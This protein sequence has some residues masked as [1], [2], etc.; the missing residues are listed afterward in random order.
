MSITVKQIAEL[1][2]VSRGTVDRALKGRS[3][4]NEKTKEKILEIAKQYDYK[5]NLIGKALVYS[6]Q[7]ITVKVILNSIGNSFFTDIKDGIFDA[8]KE[9]SDYGIKVELTELKG[10]D[11]NEMLNA[12]NSVGEDIKNLII[13][14][15]NNEKTRNKINELVDNGVN[16]ITLTSDLENSKRLSYIGCDYLKSGKIMGRLAGIV[17]NGNSK[18]CITTGNLNHSGH[19]DRVQGVKDI[20]ASYENIEIAQVIQNDDDDNL[21]Y[22]KLSELL[23][24]DENID[25]VCITTGGVKGSLK[26]IKECNRKLKICCFDETPTTREAL[27]NGDILAIVCQQPYEQGYNAI[28]TVFDKVVAQQ[29]IP[30]HQYTKLNIK[31]DQSI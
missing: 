10:Y 13:T 17:T 9:Y 24:K 23:S 22:E 14:P 12:L 31:I 15:I 1:A 28:K 20:L 27:M 8:Q 16:V 6:N 5:P 25:C 18:I 19:K 11:E 30:S 26:A 21:A 29:E 3:G 4:V 7:D 2:G